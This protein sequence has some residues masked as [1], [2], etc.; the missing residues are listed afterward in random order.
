[1]NQSRT[2]ASGAPLPNSL[3]ASLS[4]SELQY[5]TDVPVYVT[6]NA[7]NL[8]VYVA[9]L[10]VTIL[11]GYFGLGRDV[12]GDFKKVH[13]DYQ[14]LITPVFWTYSMWIV[15]FFFELIFT[16]AQS[17]TPLR[18]LSIVQDG[19]SYNFVIIHCCHIAWVVSYVFKSPLV[20]TL[21]MLLCVVFLYSLCNNIYAMDSGY[22]PASGGGTVVQPQNID[23]SM[24]FL[25]FRFPFHLHFGW[26]VIMLL[27]NICELGQSY[28]WS[29]QGALAFISL[30]IIWVLG[31][32]SLFYPE[33]PN[34]TVPVIL[35]WAMMGIYVELTPARAMVVDSF[36]DTTI[37]KIRT[38]ALVICVEHLVLSILR[39]I[40]HFSSFYYVEP[41]PSGAPPGSLAGS[42]TG[43][44][45]LSVRGSF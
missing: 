13:D 43:S 28:D 5:V 35:A 37:K 4:F 36:Q 44:Q 6:T 22:A 14:T 20:A 38:G 31:T 26:A 7:M 29:W 25:I 15:I 27:V 18:K 24:E 11:I 39:F 21:F 10:A 19:I 41:R 17:L 34:F 33:Y 23:M 16:V 9:S 40:V 1:M 3:N 42:Q 45:R 32:L 12:K 2:G 30:G 8:I